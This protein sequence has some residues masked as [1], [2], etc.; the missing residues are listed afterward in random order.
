MIVHIHTS[1]PEMP[2]FDFSIP[3]RNPLLDLV[4]WGKNHSNKYSCLE[5]QLEGLNVITYESIQY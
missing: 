4:P 1:G 2:V 5:I 3:H